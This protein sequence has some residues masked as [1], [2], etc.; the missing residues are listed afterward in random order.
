MVQ[1]PRVLEIQATEQYA[2]GARSR[3][4]SV[5]SV[6]SSQST[7]SEASCCSTSSCHCNDNASRS[8]GKAKKA[9]KKSHKKKDKKILMTNT[10][11]S[12]F[13]VDTRWD[14]DIE[15]LLLSSLLLLTYVTPDD[16]VWKIW[17]AFCCY[18]CLCRLLQAGW[19][20][21]LNLHVCLLNTFSQ[22]SWIS[23]EI[24]YYTFIRN[25]IMYYYNSY[26]LDIRK[27]I[28]CVI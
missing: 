15:S 17:S 11:L 5:N 13:A 16:L 9:T 7:G 12:Y 4:S 3:N 1:H 26:I 24:I 14:R 6:T 18:C 19:D 21:R 22:I 27:K 28:V 2:D 8:Q 25:C 20:K 10:L 23:I